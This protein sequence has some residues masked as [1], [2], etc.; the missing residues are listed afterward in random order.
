MQT[1]TKYL[2]ALLRE[3]DLGATKTMSSSPIRILLGPCANSFNTNRLLEKNFIIIYNTYLLCCFNFDGLLVVLYCV[4]VSSVI[5][6]GNILFGEQNFAQS[7]RCT[8]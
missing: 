5:I 3:I 8:S 2:T 7:L 6:D 1:I 4:L